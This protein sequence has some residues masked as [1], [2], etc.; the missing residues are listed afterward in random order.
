MEEVRRQ[1]QTEKATKTETA[2][3]AKPTTISSFDQQLSH[4]GLHSGQLGV[5]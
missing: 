5:D 3:M 4:S 1:Q 2:A